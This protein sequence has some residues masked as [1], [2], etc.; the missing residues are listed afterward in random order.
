MRLPEPHLYLAFTRGLGSFISI[1]YFCR[2]K[3]ISLKSQLTPVPYQWTNSKSLIDSLSIMSMKITIFYRPLELFHSFT[4]SSMRLF[5]V[6][7][8]LI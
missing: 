2:N 1:S 8:I 4:D 3:S 5:V 6:L 7:C